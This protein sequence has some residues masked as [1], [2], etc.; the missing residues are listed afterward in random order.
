[1]VT[2]TSSFSFGSVVL[3]PFPFADQSGSKKHP[4]VAVSSHGYN[5]R[6]RDIVIMAIHESGAPAARVG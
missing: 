6:R 2:G 3:V 5:N 4:A 1:M